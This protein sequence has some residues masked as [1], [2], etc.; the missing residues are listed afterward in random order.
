MND[1]TENRR[2]SGI[3]FTDIVG[4]SAIMQ[5]SESAAMKLLAD[6]KSIVKPIIENYNGEI[7]KPQGDGFM[8]DFS[9]V[10]DAVRCAMDIQKEISNYNR[11]ETED[12]KIRLRIGIHMGDLI[13]K[14]ND[15]FG[16]DVNVASRI[17]KLSDPGGICISQTVYDQI[18]NKV[19]IDTLELGETELKNI[20]DKVNIYKVLLEAQE[21]IDP[22]DTNQ[23]SQESKQEKIP[24]DESEDATSDIKETIKKKIK[25]SIGASIPN[26]DIKDGDDEIKIGAGGIEVKEKDGDHVK[27]DLSGIKVKEKDGTDIEIGLSGIKIKDKNDKK[28]KK[29]TKIPPKKKISNFGKAII[30]LISGSAFLILIIGLFTDL[31]DF[32]PYGV[33]YFFAI[34]IVGSSL[35]T[36]LKHN[37]KKTIIKLMSGGVFMVIITGLFTD[38]YDFWPYGVIGVLALGVLIGSLKSLLGE[39]Y[40]YID[41]DGNKK[42]WDPT[43][44]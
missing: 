13:I 19:E 25:D 26:I 10:V 35:K 3:M 23:D 30:Q 38:L 6:H 41:K 21:K 31:Y 1:M 28:S 17:E 4:Y 27:I 34:A 7:L 16:H 33:I 42:N 18:K 43:A 22:A 37:L 11:E 12:E 24:E 44:N 8:I 20:E 2:L 14:D 32:W 40:D 5:K 9:S 15:I 39:D 29:K 36:L